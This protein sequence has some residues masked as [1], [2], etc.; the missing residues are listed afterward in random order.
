MTQKNIT[1]ETEIILN[2]LE[3]IEGICYAA[4]QQ[5]MQLYGPVNYK[6]QKP[7]NPNPTA[8][9]QMFTPEVAKLLAF[10]KHEP[11]WIIKPK[12][13]LGAENFAKISNI[14]R[15]MGGEYCA[16]NRETNTPGHYKVHTSKVK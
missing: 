5:I 8:I 15:S 12:A 1:K 10:E 6:E 11:Y 3:A 14:V 4:R 9:E 13:F 16:A 7:T 2:T